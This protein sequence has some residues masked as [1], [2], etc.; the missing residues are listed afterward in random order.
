MVVSRH[1][2]SAQLYEYNRERGDVARL[3]RG[4]DDRLDGCY[5][6][7]GR[8]AFVHV[9]RGRRGMRMRIAVTETDGSA[10]LLSDGPADTRV[11]WSPDGRWVLYQSTLRNGR[12]VIKALD[13]EDPD[14]E[15]R[16]VARGIE[17]AISPLGD[18]VVYARERD[19]GH[20]LWRMRPDGS[21]KT[22]LGA[23]AQG[24]A[25][26]RNPT[27]SPD[28][29]FVAYVAVEGHRQRIRIRRMDGTG[30]RLLLED[31]DG[32]LPVW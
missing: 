31:A 19:D 3:L 27:I 15:P 30:D 13:M 9:D 21:G 29:G 10:T 22:A 23:R 4:H 1:R 5:G 26:E 8:I 11:R 2:G 32:S 6:P 14:P 12:A 18:W 16:V 24:D 7:D 28:G 17:H 20:D 25:D